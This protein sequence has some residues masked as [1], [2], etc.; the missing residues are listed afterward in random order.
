M[1]SAFITDDYKKEDIAASLLRM[2]CGS[3]VCWLS[4]R[5]RQEK[6][7]Q[8]LLYA[9]FID[10]KVARRI[11]TECITA[12]NINWCNLHNEVHDTSHII[13]YSKTPI[14]SCQPA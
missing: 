12:S 3:L 11:L 2:W 5:A 8:V 6:T 10:N 4:A 1:C 7:R 13:M 9:S 14:H